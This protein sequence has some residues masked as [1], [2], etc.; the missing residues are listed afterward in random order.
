MAELATVA[1]PYAQALF[2]VCGSEAPAAQG[3]LNALADAVG[4]GDLLRLATDPRLRAN[5]VFDAIRAALG[6][7]LPERG[8]NFL[9]TVV[10][11]GRLALL[12]EI[13]RQFRTLAN[14]ASSVMDGVVYTPF[15][16]SEEQLADM[17][18]ALERHFARKLR[19]TQQA[20]PDL[21]G[22][23]R[24]VVGDE[25]LDSSVRARLERMKTALIAR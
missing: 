5:Q 3:W 20:A 21:I 2:E 13:A 22:G 18:P 15:A 6:A 12:P 23:V 8:V 19:L 17:Q 14:A 16:L 24:V 25:V 11:N 4:E 1:R 10:D 7:K 9:R